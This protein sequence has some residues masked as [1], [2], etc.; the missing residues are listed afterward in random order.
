[1]SDAAN[2]IRFLDKAA[3]P[4]LAWTLILISLG[5]DIVMAMIGGANFGVLVAMWQDRG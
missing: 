4:A 3:G 2:V 5:G 1:M